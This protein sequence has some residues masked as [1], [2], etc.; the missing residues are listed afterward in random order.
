[1]RRGFAALPHSDVGAEGTVAHGH[2]VVPPEKDVGLSELQLARRSGHVRRAQHHEHRILVELE[3]RPLVR[4]VGVFDRQIVQAELL[5]DLPQHVLFGLVEA[6]PDEL[7]GTREC[8]PNLI[9][10][11]IG[12][13]G[14]AAICGAVDD[15]GWRWHRRRRDKDV[16][17]LLSLR[18]LRCPGI[19]P[20]EC[21]RPMDSAPA[22]RLVL[23]QGTLDM[24]VLQTLQWGPQHGY[25][26]T[27]M[28]RARSSE[29]LQVETGSL[30]PALHRLERQGWVKAEW[31]QTDTNQQAK[32]YRLTAAGKKQL[33][34]ER[35]RWSQLVA[36]IGGVLD[37][38]PAKG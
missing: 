21:L 8:R 36:A 28:I 2:Q 4:V 30:Y 12:D 6:E 23:L 1:M 37:A 24:L 38:G 31:G 19:N 14:A 17:H 33:V 27:Q 35:D 22:S 25:A 3:L 10:G 29:A 16:C 9:D 15:R 11:Q 13:S 18:Q 5:L 26:I 20:V 7:I 32:F 34:R